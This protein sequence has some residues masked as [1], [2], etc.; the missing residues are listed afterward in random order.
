VERVRLDFTPPA[1]T[2]T[3][4]LA[5]CDG[6]PQARDAANDLWLDLP[7]CDEGEHAVTAYFTVSELPPEGAW[8]AVGVGG[9]AF[10]VDEAKSAPP[11]YV[12]WFDPDGDEPESTPQRPE[13]Q[14]VVAVTTDVAGNEARLE[15]GRLRFDF[16]APS[17][18]VGPESLSGIVYERAPWGCEASGYQPRMQLSVAPDAF[19]E[20]GEVRV[21]SVLDPAAPGEDPGRE[22]YVRSLLGS[23]AFSPGVESTVHAGVGDRPMVHFSFTDRAGN[24]SDSDDER[25]RIQATA[26]AEVEWVA[27]GSDHVVPGKPWRGGCDVV[28]QS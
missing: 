11:Y 6:R 19:D 7:V 24:E 28:G 14:P 5:R 20:E 1:L 13:G 2:G 23:G 12:A 25:L 8:P 16:T 17:V 18:P 10:V 9:E 26:V 3:P 15:L 21:W 22:L 27:A 4:T